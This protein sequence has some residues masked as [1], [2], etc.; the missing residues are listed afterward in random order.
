MDSRSLLP[1][2]RALLQRITLLLLLGLAGCPQTLPVASTPSDGHAENDAQYMRSFRAML[3]EEPGSEKRAKLSH[4]VMSLQLAFADDDFRSRS[5]SRGLRVALGALSLRSRS[6]ETKIGKIS[7]RAMNAL[8]Q[9][10][11]QS[12]ETGNEGV[13]QALYTLLR[14]HLES[15]D[16]AEVATVDAHLK[17]LADWDLSLIHI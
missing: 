16:P 17:A 1:M 15:T 9:A 8:R 11:E 5:M 14:A 7:P 3:A 10:A 2:P 4:E 12:A 6:S 13:S